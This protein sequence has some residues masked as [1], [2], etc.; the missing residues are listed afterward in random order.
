MSQ[1]SRSLACGKLA[2]LREGSE[3]ELLLVNID[4]PICIQRYSL[5]FPNELLKPKM[6]QC[7]L[8]S[9]WFSSSFPNWL[10]Q[11]AVPSKMP[12]KIFFVNNI[13][14]D[15]IITR[16]HWQN[17]FWSLRCMSVRAKPDL[18][19]LCSGQKKNITEGIVGE[20]QI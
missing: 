5:I 16:L 14:T 7:Q 13:Q 8:L 19:I 6:V 12:T 1:H 10:A 18:N 9:H 4:F 11:C 20:R 17:L 2:C 15:L 3:P